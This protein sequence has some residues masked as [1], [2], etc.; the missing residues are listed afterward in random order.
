MLD[1]DAFA[2]AWARGRAMSLE[3]AVAEALVEDA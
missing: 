3:E 1:S 2:E